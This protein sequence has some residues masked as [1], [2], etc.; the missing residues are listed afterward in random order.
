MRN[1]QPITGWG[2]VRLSP[3]RLAAICTSETEALERQRELGPDYIVRFGVGFG[4][5]SDFFWETLND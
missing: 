1:D 2:V 3:W 5:S 4:R